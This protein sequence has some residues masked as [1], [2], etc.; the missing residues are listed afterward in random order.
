MKSFLLEIGT[1]HMPARFIPPALEQLQKLLEERLKAERLAF[2]TSRTFGTPRRLA[3]LVKGLSEKS[4][5][6]EKIA[7]GPSAKMLKGPDGQFTAAAA[8]F[9]RSQGVAPEALKVVQSPKGEVLEARRV[10]PG[11]GAPAV[12]S[13]ILPEIIAQLQFA[14]GLAWEPSGFRF[15]IPDSPSRA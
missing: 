4:E 6:A 10:I 8:G 2:A 15:G 14:K 11:E 5:A 13:R 3:I 1:E 7:L 12:L 9:A